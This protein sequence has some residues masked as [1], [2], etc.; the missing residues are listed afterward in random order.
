MLLLT[1]IISDDC[2]VVTQFCVVKDCESLVNFM[3]F[4]KYCETVFVTNK[5]RNYLSLINK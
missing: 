1:E 4:T 2:V 3:F 5:L